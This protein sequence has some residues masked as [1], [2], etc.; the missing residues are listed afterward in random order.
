MSKWVIL[1][2]FAAA[3]VFFYQ[4]QLQ[5]ITFVD[6]FQFV[7]AVAEPTHQ[8]EYEKA[9]KTV[10]KKFDISSKKVD[11]LPQKP[12]KK[13]NILAFGDVMLGR[14]VRILMDQN[15]LDYSFQKMNTAENIFANGA[16]VVFGNLEGPIHGEGREGGTA[17]SFS[18]NTDVAQVL[19][20]FGFTMM[21]IANNHALDEGSEGRQTTIEA[22]D[23][24]GIGWC[25]NA[26][27]V[28]PA[29]V[30]YNTV[31]DKKFAFVCFHSATHKLD[32]EA[33]TNLIKELRPKVDYLIVSIHW[34]IEY[35]H[36]PNYELQVKPAHAFIDAGADFIIGHHPHVVESFEIYNGKMIFY[37]LGNFIFDQYWSQDTQEELAIGISLDKANTGGSFHTKVDLFPMKSERSQPHMMIDDERG[38]WLDKFIGYGDYDDTMQAEIRRGV[39]EIP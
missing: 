17:M 32:L 25:G 35:Q 9:P 22:L 2:G 14:Y 6:V 1:T 4:F 5:K 11:P 23:G 38:K 20:N 16:D 37:S 31:G 30:Y 26:N 21:S 39:I 3:A 19:K 28:D 12:D 8:I 27:E 7:E 13:L 36:K 18:F 24:A 15:G 29:S 34:G 10:I 33:A